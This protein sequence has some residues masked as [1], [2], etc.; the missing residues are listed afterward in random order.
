VVEGNRC[1]GFSY[2]IIWQIWRI[3]A[4][5]HIACRAHAVPLPCRAA[6]GLEC[7]SP[8]WFTQCGRVWFTLAMPRPCHALTMPRPWEERHG[9][10][11]AWTRHGKCESHTAALCKSNG[12]QT[13]SKP[14]AAPHGRGT[15]WARH[16]MCESALTVTFRVRAD[17]HYTSRMRSVTVPSERSVFTLSF[18]FSHL[19]QQHMMGGLRLFPSD[20]QP[21]ATEFIFRY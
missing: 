5:S 4:D 18:V 20:I 11:M 13:H 17:S 16:A 6:K 2:R 8:I 7:F 9:Q 3:K 14:L 19:P 12:S 15:A 1:I 10:S 21:I